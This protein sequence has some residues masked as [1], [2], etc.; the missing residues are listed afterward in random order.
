METYILSDLVSD[1]YTNA[2]GYTLYTF[3]EKHIASDDK[4]ELSFKGASPTSSSFLNSSF[5][6]LIEKYGFDKFKAH[7]K[8]SDLS[9]SQASV[10]KRYF[11]SCGEMT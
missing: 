4:V 8:L 3:L 9:K 10:L 2:S 11:I 7:L 5:G 1:T 6:E